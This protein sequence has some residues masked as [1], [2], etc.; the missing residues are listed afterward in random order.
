LNNSWRLSSLAAQNVATHS[1]SQLGSVTWLN[2]TS[3]WIYYQ[4]P[5]SQM[6][7]F[8]MVDYRDQTWRDGSVGVLGLALNGTGIGVA[9][10][11][12]DGGEVMELFMQVAGDAVHA[13]LFISNAWTSDWYDI[14]GAPGAVADGSSLAAATIDQAD[15]SMVLLAYFS[16]TGFIT[17]QSRGTINITD[18]STYSTPQQLVEGDSSSRTGLAAISL[19]GEPKVYFVNN[20]TILELSGTTVAAA[21]WTT[22]DISAL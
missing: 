10:W 17:I 8:G 20:Q 9:R 11:L 1:L 13:R 19:S 4:D 21:N 3:S 14:D 22:K 6:R 12:K 16:K 2:G 7:E 15:G 5:N 18:Y